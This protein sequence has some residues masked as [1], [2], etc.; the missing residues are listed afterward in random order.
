MSDSTRKREFFEIH[1]EFV[2]VADP[3]VA[4]ALDLDTDGLGTQ[5]LRGAM[6]YLNHINEQDGV[7]AD[8]H[9]SRGETEDAED[10]RRPDHADGQEGPVRPSHPRGDGNEQERDPEQEPRDA[11]DA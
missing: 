1:N 7:H 10:E 8:S 4:E 9:P 11:E 5:T 6:S 2:A 3:E